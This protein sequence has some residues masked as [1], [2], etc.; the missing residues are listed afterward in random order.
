MRTTRILG[1]AL[2]TSALLIGSVTV[3]HPAEA[4]QA[5]SGAV[6]LRWSNIALRTLYVERSTFIPGGALYMG[7]MSLAVHDAVTTANKSIVGRGHASSVA[8]AAVAAHDVLA[9]YFP[10]AQANLD[11]DLTVELNAIPSSPAKSRGIDVGHESAAEM[12]ASRTGDGRDAAV[13]YTRAPA[14]GVWRPTPSANA[15]MAGPWLGFVRPLLL[16]SPTQIQPD[17]PDALTSAEYTADFNE[18]KTMGALNNSGRTPA[19]TEI[20]LFY[21]ANS[22]LQ[23]QRA[24]ID[25]VERHPVD[26]VAASRLFAL[27]NAGVADALITCWRLKYDVALWRPITAIQEAADDGNAD[28]T[29]DATWSPLV[30]TPPYPDYVSG[31]ASITNAFT[32]ALRI[33][34]GTDATDLNVF[35]SVTGTTRHYGSLDTLSRD[36]FN[37]RIWLGIHFRD[38]MEGGVHVGE[39]SARIANQ[40]LR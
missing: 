14:V 25:H 32:E 2:C 26:I 20:A 35:S 13:L 39:D 11:A 38:A 8:A 31:H 27:V 21:N 34:F 19:Q 3:T 5:P 16:D 33:T 12:V 22:V 4:K 28:T 15:P 37:A 9:T 6:V 24:L 17:G 29:A 36:A 23:M 18:V 1:A 7:F 10:A 40:R 30:A